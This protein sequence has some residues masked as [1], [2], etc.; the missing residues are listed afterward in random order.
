MGKLSKRVVPTGP[1]LALGNADLAVCSGVAVPVSLFKR[2]GALF[3]VNFILKAS[4]D[5]CTLAC[6]P[7][8]CCAICHGYEQTWRLNDVLV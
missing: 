6:W 1:Y 3:H 8:D 4:T 2:D 5:L 7:T